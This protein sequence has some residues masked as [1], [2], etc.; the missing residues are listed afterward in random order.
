MLGVLE[1]TGKGSG[2]LRRREASYL[3]AR[4]DVHVGDRLI[5]SYGLRTG[6][7]IAGTTRPGGKGRGPS[8]QTITA[9]HGRAPE[10]LRQRPEFSRLTAM[11]PNE[12]LR[13][14]SNGA[15]GPQSD[16][17]NRVIDLLCPLG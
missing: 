5:R 7:E 13:L 17:T 16:Y 11:H 15:A 10:E 4:G 14:E 6:D 12:Q 9:I 1:L 3:P 2:F 8:L